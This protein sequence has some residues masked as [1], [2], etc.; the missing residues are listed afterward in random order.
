MPNWCFNQVDI[1]GDE[2]E[3]QQVVEL[4]EKARSEGGELFKQILPMPA[5]IEATTQGGFPKFHD[6]KGEP[7]NWYSWRMKYWGTKWDTNEIDYVLCDK[8]SLTI[9]LFTAYLPSLPVIQKLSELIPNVGIRHRFYELHALIV[10]TAEFKGGEVV[11]YST[12]EANKETME[13]HGFDTDYFDAM[14][15]TTPS[16]ETK[17]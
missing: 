6:E 10:G 14:K 8:N 9:H 2:K 16:S 7:T 17:E 15:S 4:L 3:I 12:N 5:D 11:S 13:L 1:K